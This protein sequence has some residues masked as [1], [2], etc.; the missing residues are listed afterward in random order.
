MLTGCQGTPVF[1][2]VHCFLLQSAHNHG[3]DPAEQLRGAEEL[4]VQ[5]E[6]GSSAAATPSSHGQTRRSSN[7]AVARVNGASERPLVNGV[8]V[9]ES[10]GVELRGPS[11][12]G[13]SANG[14]SANGASAPSAPANG[15]VSSNGA[16]DRAVSNGTLG[17]AVNNGAAPRIIPA[18]C[19]RVLS[20]TTDDC[21]HLAIEP[22]TSQASHCTLAYSVLVTSINSCQA[23]AVSTTAG[24]K[25]RST[26]PRMALDRRQRQ[27]RPS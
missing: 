17:G 27:Q 1:S 22:A 23:C 5:P 6:N 16:L 9:I 4:L 2:L 10:P 13:A 20:T 11:A 18:G 19:K 12:N 24:R 3:S 15:A 25:Q 21:V 8:A 14:T 26:M 7:R